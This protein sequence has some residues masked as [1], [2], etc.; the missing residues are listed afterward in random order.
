MLGRLI[1]SATGRAY[2]DLLEERILRPQ[3]LD[4]VRP[5][6][7]SILPDIAPGYS[8][9]ARNLKKDGRMKFDP[10]SEWTGGGLAT[11][12]TMLV[13]FH[14]ALAEGRIVQPES[15]ALML[16]SGWRNPETPGDHCGFGLF[17]FNGGASFGHGGMW[18][19]Y[20]TEVLHDLSSGTTIAVQTNRDGRLDMRSLVARIAALVPSGSSNANRRSTT[21]RSNGS[22]T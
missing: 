21:S 10:S 13:Q 17:V 2:Y 15:F 3:D 18:S 22:R 12:P 16:D 7:Q 14:A 6:N 1:E 4:Q 19:G 9:G 8:R 11:N 5:A 20:R